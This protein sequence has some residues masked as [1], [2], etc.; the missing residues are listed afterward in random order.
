MLRLQAAKNQPELAALHL[1]LTALACILCCVNLA[2][3][4]SLFAV[5]LI[6]CSSSARAADWNVIRLENRDYVSF[7]N[8]AQFYQFPQY[9]RVNRNVSLRNDRRGLRA[10]AGTSEI[11]I[12][13]VRSLAIFRFSVTPMTL[14]FLPWT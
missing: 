13:G 2:T 7:A 12:N 6:L 3:N 5:A 9:T 10:Q 8:V 4:C 1:R 14:S 11:N